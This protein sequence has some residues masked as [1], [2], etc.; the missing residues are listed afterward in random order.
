V[1]PSSDE[2]T[3]QAQAIMER[4]LKLVTE[5]R[6]VLRALERGEPGESSS[7][8][9]ERILY[10]TLMS[11]ID[12]GLIRTMEDALQVLRHA[13]QPL[14]P[15]GK[16]MSEPHGRVWKRHSA[17]CPAATPYRQSDSV[18]QP[19]NIQPQ[20]TASNLQSLLLTESPS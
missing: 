15:M 8:E 3:A 19:D 20:T 13:S 17:H 5:C 4:V 14:G 12:D 1:T 2:P 11:A 7:A 6:A 9:A 18:G 16:E 10:F